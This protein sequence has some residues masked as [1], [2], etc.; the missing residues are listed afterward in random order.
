MTR[1]D[2]GRGVDLRLWR[3]LILLL[4][5]VLVLV[6]MLGVYGCLVAVVF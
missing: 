1:I 4:L 6:L 2:Y 3:L 5:L